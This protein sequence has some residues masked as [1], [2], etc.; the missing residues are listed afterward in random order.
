MEEDKPQAQALEVANGFKMTE[1]GPLPEHWQVV[2][3]GEVGKFINGY[4]FKPSDWVNKGLP[5]IRIQNLNDPRKSFNYFDGNLDK[6]YLIKNG[7]LLISWSAS[8]GVFI[9]NGQDAWLNQHIFKAVL[10]EGISKEYIYFCLLNFFILE[11][12]AHLHGS[13]M[14]HIVKE[15]F[16]TLSIP[17]PPLPEQREIARI[18]QAVDQKIQAEER[19]KQALEELFKTLLSHLMTGKIRVNHLIQENEEEIS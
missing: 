7:D 8:L 1:L 5:I 10:D 15:K 17:L 4:P 11:A 12:S 2:R 9:W 13:T 18:L 19:R 16:L 14:K 6:R 3:L